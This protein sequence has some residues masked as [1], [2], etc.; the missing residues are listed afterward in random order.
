MPCI[1]EMYNIKQYLKDIGI[2]QKEFAERLGLSRPTLDTYIDMF[3]GNQTIPKERYDIIFNRL[4]GAKKASADEFQMRLQKVENLLNR[5]QKYGTSDLSAEAA[6]YV[7]SVVNTMTKDLK[8]ENWNKDVYIF[9]NILISNYRKNEIFQQL[10]EYFIYLNNIRSIE[11]IE[12]K[13]KS[14]FANMYKAFHG[15]IESPDFYCEKDYE[16]FLVRCDE[17]KKEKIKRND[18]RK[19]NLK[20]R[21]KDMVVEHEK[22][23]IDL[24]EEEIIEAI[25]RQLVQERN[26][27]E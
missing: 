24:S 22:K 1:N 2:T 6:D 19:N 21:I 25:K 26:K 12:E 10:V 16:D 15:L 17:I 13:Q 27:G 14:Y 8:E 7:S 23:G 3:E 11:Q 9:I 4:F 18:E 5:D 20:K